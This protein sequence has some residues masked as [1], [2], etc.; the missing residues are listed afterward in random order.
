MSERTGLTHVASFVLRESG[1][2]APLPEI[3]AA[4]L[5]DAVPPPAVEEAVP[6]LAEAL[7]ALAADGLLTVRRF[8]TWPAAWVDGASVAGERLTVETRVAG[9]WLPGPARDGLL[10]ARVTE[11]G[12]A[13]L[14]RA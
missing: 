14:G 7:T 9:T 10:V 8:R 1:S 13:Y 2:D 5:A 11:A 6:A 12:R 4:W 3:A